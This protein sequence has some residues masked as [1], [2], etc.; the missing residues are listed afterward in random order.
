MNPDHSY[1]DS[2]YYATELAIVSP[3]GC[4]ANDTLTINLTRPALPEA[5]FIQSSDV[6]SV[7]NSTIRF[8]NQSTNA[9]HY[10]W[11]FGDG[12]SSED[13]DPIHQFDKVG[14]NTVKLISYN[15]A[16]CYDEYEMNV[17]IVPMYIPSGFTP[18]NDGKNDVWFD[19]TPVLNVK[20]F[21][22]Q[23]LDRWGGTVYTSDS[24]LRPWDG[25]FSS[26]KQAPVGVYT[27]YIQITSEK[28]KDYEFRGTFSLVR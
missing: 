11:S 8:T 12:Q 6:S 23:V 18:N 21:K 16:G 5:K 22:M 15:V 3:W 13:A 14:T 4:K 20:S 24:Y 28:G 27:Y 17:E 9:T 25:N 1:R 7:F 2:G 10:K 19:G 26:G